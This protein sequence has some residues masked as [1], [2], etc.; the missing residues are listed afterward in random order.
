MTELHILP[1]LDDNYAYAITE[2]NKAVIIDPG[3]AAPI[4]SFLSKYHLDLEMIINTHHHGDHTAGN[5]ALKADYACPVAAPGDDGD[6]KLCEGTPLS[7]RSCQFQILATPG[8]TLDHITLVED[9]QKWLF[10]GDVLFQLGC[11]RVFEGT[12]Q[13]MYKSLQT[14]KALPDDLCVYC[15]HDYARGNARFALSLGPNPVA[16][17]V[18]QEPQDKRIGIGQT[19]GEEKSFNPFLRCNS[20]DEFISRRLAKDNF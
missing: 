9:Q 8:H 19:L 10:C 7:W 15:G 11:G 14:I 18:L 17:S 6:I 5:Q 4:R 20:L 2:Q 16:E 13:Q 12:M 1:I 3:E